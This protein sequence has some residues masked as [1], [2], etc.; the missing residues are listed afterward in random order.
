MARPIW[1]TPTALRSARRRPRA[2]VLGVIVGLFALAAI[3]ACSANGATWQASG[4]GGPTTTP[5]ASA[6]LTVSLAADVKDISP[7]DPVSVSITRGTLDAVS[8]TN[9]DGKAVKGDFDEKKTSWVNSEKL[10]YGK[11]Y[12]LTVA[13]TGEDG[14]P[15][16]VTRTF[17]TL[18][19][20]NQTIAYLRANVGTLLDGGTYGVGQP[21]VVWFDEPIK[22]KAAAEKLLTVTTD[23]PGVVGGWY[24]MDTHELHWRPKDYWQTGT[25]VTV[26]ANIYGRDLG[27]GLYGQY[28]ST[29][30][31]TIGHKHVAIADHDT[32]MMK[33]YVD[34]VQ[35]TNIAGH[36]VT[37]GI[38]ISMGKGGTETQPSGVVVDFRTNSGPHVVTLKYDVFR[39][40]SA[41]F[42]I[43]DPKSPNYYDENIKKAVRISGDGEF[44]HLADWNIPQQGH[45]N[46]SHGCINVAPTYINWFFDTFTAGDVVDVKNTTKNLDL[47]NGLG[48]WVL[49]WDAWLKGSALA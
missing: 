35:V 3:S 26:K 7:A 22:D 47:R 45:Y 46:T 34:D 37:A 41:S 42:G 6:E 40:T 28:D 31:F 33:V 2:R 20:K 24:W 13:G 39:M 16:S 9:A 18:T 43:T 36:D 5:P 4:E 11:T 49:S 1:R 30:T 38:P 8:L 12:T 19:P 23:P 21:V 32:K 10:G 25:K 27:G 29:A 17:T 44:V 15:Q 14:K 48:D